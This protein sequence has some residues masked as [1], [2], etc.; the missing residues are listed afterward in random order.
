MWIWGV[1][2]WKWGKRQRRIFA[3]L[4]TIAANKDD[5]EERKISLISN[6]HLDWIIRRAEDVEKMLMRNIKKGKEKIEE[7]G[8]EKKERNF[9]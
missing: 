4:K 9:K 8:E 7:V 1:K 3:Q 5:E 2:K 6:P